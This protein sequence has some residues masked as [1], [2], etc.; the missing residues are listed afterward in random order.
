[1]ANPKYLTRAEAAE[2]LQARGVHRTRAT[3][4]KLA[5]SGSGPRYRKFGAGRGARALYTPDDLDSWIDDQLSAPAATT[6]GHDP[7]NI[8]L[9]AAGRG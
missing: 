2:Y 1:M 5:V 8:G 3:L 7:S 4:A 6:S 9:A